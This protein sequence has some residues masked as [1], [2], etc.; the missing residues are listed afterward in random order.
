MT[1]TSSY[2]KI[3]QIAWQHPKALKIEATSGTSYTIT[4]N[5]KT[6]EIK[7][8]VFEDGSTD[9]TKVFNGSSEVTGYNGK[10][11]LDLSNV[12]SDAS[13]TLTIDGKKY[14]L[15]EAKTISAV[16]ITS[17]IAFT[18]GAS[19]VLTLKTGFVYTLIVAED[20]KMKVV[21]RQRGA[22]DGSYYLVGNFFNE[23]GENINYDKKYFR[24]IN[25]KGDG[26]LYFDIPA[27]LTV[28][29][30]VYGADGKC[31][32]PKDNKEIGIDKPASTDDV[33][34]N[35]EMVAGKDNYWSFTDRGF[36]EGKK[37]V[38]IYRVTIK[39]DEETG[40]PSTWNIT[41]D[42]TKR[43]AYF[44]VDPNEDIDAVAQ[45]CYTDYLP[46]ENPDKNG[47][48]IFMVIF[49]WKQDSIV[50]L[51]VISRSRQMMMSKKNLL[52]L[53]QNC[54]GKEMVA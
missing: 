41:Y 25:N 16:G 46:K 4:Y 54:I 19:E 40:V 33:T 27:S 50:S 1:L 52:I 34:A 23:D 26:N 10:Y 15:A 47:P 51:W 9:V 39:V 8:D 42:K 2:Q 44:L 12:T 18:E 5:H 6:K 36:V 21:A 38:G 14:G 35:G 32:G 20:G 31:Y 28:K 37:Q 29:A 49:I 43:M 17:D 22:A 7:Y 24:F 53:Q 11:T 3:Y 48:I 45:P 30:Q 13:I